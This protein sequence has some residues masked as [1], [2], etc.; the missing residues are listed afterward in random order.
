MKNWKSLLEKALAKEYK[1]VTFKWN[2][3]EMSFFINALVSKAANANRQVAM[4]KYILFFLAGW[5]SAIIGFE[6]A[7]IYGNISALASFIVLV[8]LFNKSAT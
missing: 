1:G 6:I 5:F 2:G 3:N 8:A 4:H 7:P